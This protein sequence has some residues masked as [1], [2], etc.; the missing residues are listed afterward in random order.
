MTRKLLTYVLAFLLTCGALA[1]YAQTPT[2]A[3]IRQL[4]EVT[5]AKAL[6]LS[7][8]E[9]KNQMMEQIKSQLHTLYPEATP[10]QSAVIDQMMLEMMNL[11]S[12]EFSWDAL[13]QSVMGL[14][15]KFY[16]QAEVNAMISFYSSPEGQSIVKKMPQ[17]TREVVIMMQQRMMTVMPEMQRI[18]T[19]AMTRLQAIQ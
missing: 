16:T 7:T 1:A 2:D 10:E 13:E 4:L 5:D 19:N 9:V 12:K 15:R 11:L 17:L 6:M 3:S 8:Q 18:L 14:Y